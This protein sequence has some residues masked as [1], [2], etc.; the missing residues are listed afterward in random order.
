MR[1][2]FVDDTH[3][4]HFRHLPARLASDPAN[5][6]RFAC[7]F[8][9]G[10]PAPGVAL[11][12]IPLIRPPS[13]DTHHYT[14]RLSRAAAGGLAAYGACRRLAADGF[15]PDVIVAFSGWGLAFFLKDAFPEAKLVVYND[16]FTWSRWSVYDFFP[17]RRP[18]VDRACNLHFGNAANLMDLADC[19][20]CMVTT[21]WQLSSFPE[22]FRPKMSVIH[23]GID[24]ELFSPGGSSQPSR[25]DRHRSPL[26]GV[27]LP[28][29][30][31]LVTY[32]T[33]GQEPYRGFEQFLRAA[34]RLQRLRPRVHVLIGGDDQVHYSFLPPDGSPTWRDHLLPQL[35]LDPARTHFTGPLA[36]DDVLACLRASDA[37]VYLSA[38]YLP[39]WSLFEAMAAGCVVVG[40]RTPPV[41]E[42]ATDGVEALLV[43][44]FDHEGLAD[45]LSWALDHQADLAPLRERARAR[46]VR[47]Y[48]LDEALGRQVRLLGDVLEGRPP[49]EVEGWALAPPPAV[50]PAV[51]SVVS[52]AVSPAGAP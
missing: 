20:W 26:A 34:E 10:S 14:R 45:R 9:K 1:V 38:P 18:D 43:D 25:A 11:V 19:D 39:S 47:D 52:P 22:V 13:A 7:Q 36:Q 28:R 17:G 37:H 32:V 24:V 49:H 16:F 4:G 41:E 29:D 35:S 40:S 2:L 5:D 8:V 23:D 48:A 51:S 12:R 46:I 31:E 33:R 42:V 30:A 50:S 44:F 15:S 27:E 3:P 21:R 6:V